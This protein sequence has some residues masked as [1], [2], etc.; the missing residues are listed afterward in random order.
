MVRASSNRCVTIT[1]P[2]PAS[3]SP[4]N[5]SPPIR[6]PSPSLVEAN[7]SFISTR[8]PGRN[9]PM[10]LLIRFS[11]SS[12]RPL[13]IFGSSSRTKWVKMP[14]RRLVVN[15]RAQTYM[16]AGIINSAIPRLRRKVDLPPEFAPVISNPG[17]W[18]ADTS[19]PT[20]VVPLNARPGLI[21][22]SVS[23]TDS[24]GEPGTGAG[25]G[26]HSG[27]ASTPTTSARRRFRQPR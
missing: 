13:T 20:G 15:E 12:N 19:L 26:S 27:R 25:R 18:S 16:P 8:P 22:C 6:A 23:S 3:I 4:P 7:D 24:A 5:T 2:T 1:T 11:S 10:I 9:D 14:V 17:A 21:N